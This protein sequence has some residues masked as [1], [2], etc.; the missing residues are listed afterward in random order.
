MHG[1]KQDGILEKTARA[2]GIPGDVVAGLP[3]VQVVGR[4]EV[5][6]HNHRGIVAYGEEEIHISGGKILIRVRGHG[7]QLRSMN[8]EDLVITGDIFAV[9]LD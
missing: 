1:R 7:L 2:F 6:M 3:S 5:Y 9:E 4:H 8:P